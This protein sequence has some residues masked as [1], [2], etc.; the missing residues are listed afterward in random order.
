MI[1]DVYTVVAGVNSQNRSPKLNAIDIVECSLMFLQAV[2][3]L[4]GFGN[5]R[6]EIRLGIHTG[7]AIG[8]VTSNQ[9]K[10][11]LFGEGINTT[12][13][14]GQS[15]KSNAVHISGATYDLV[16][17][18]YEFDVSETL[19]VENSGTKT[20]ISTYWL[21]GRKASKDIGGKL[22]EKKVSMSRTITFDQ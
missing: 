6:L 16:K 8:G 7:S 10:F 9:T 20:K 21:T 3:N 13:L 14:I 2:K 22:V 15:S 11:S 12:A 19:T 1:G 5:E 18:D 17:D 4:E